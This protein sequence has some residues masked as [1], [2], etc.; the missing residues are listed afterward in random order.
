M[1]AYLDASVLDVDPGPVEPCDVPPD[2]MCL[3]PCPEPDPFWSS[4]D[5]EYVFGNYGTILR[6]CADRDVSDTSREYIAD[7]MFLGDDLIWSKC[8]S[9][10]CLHSVA[11]RYKDHVTY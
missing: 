7:G 6:I 10:G 3:P 5:A 11:T 4:A 9:C 8:N 1:D 2:L